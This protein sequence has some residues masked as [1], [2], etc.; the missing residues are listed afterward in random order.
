MVI[1]A[2]GELKGEPV[3]EPAEIKLELPID[4]NI[5]PEYIAKEPL[6]LEAY[7]RLSEVTT[8]AE[9]E[10]IKTEWMDRY[11]P[12]PDRAAALLDVARMRAECSRIGIREITVTKAQG[13]AAGMLPGALMA[14][15]APVELKTSQ[16][17]RLQRLSRTA[18]YKLT[19]GILIVPMKPK[20]DA[21]EFLLTFLGEL[22]PR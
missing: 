16:E 17:L 11:G 21:A 19:E 13:M 1:E 3:R 7:R 4:A 22:F 10:D 15:I 18:V 14:K 20:T 6:R 12:I 2:V 9:V 8:M 5:P